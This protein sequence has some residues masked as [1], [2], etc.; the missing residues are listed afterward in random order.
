MDKDSSMRHLMEMALNQQFQL[1]TACSAEEGLALVKSD[2]VFDIVISGF[3]L[4][5]MNGV[6]F[7]SRVGEERPDT[8]RILMSGGCGNS[9]EVGRAINEGSVTKLILKPF[10][11]S[12]FLD[13]LKT[14]LA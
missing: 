7:L 9:V 1:V 10:D 12:T 5:L 13:Q 14:Y 2:V 4:V 3:T 11:L 6:E 8:V